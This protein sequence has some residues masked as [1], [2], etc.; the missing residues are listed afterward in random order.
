V[1]DYLCF[2]NLPQFPERPITGGALLKVTHFEHH[3]VIDTA[4]ILIPQCIYLEPYGALR[5]HRPD[6]TGGDDD[7][8]GGLQRYLWLLI[9]YKLR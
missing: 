5:T 4:L 9:R 7:G 3:E 8:E 2:R 1:A 6:D